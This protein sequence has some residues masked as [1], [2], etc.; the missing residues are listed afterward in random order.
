MAEYLAAL[1]LGGTS[2]CIETVD[3]GT[4]STMNV[5]SFPNRYLV[6]MAA[7]TA[8]KRLFVTDGQNDVVLVLDGWS[9][10]L[11]ATIPLLGP[12]GCLL[13]PDEK[14]LFVVSGT[15]G[16][17]KAIVNAIDTSTYAIKSSAVLSLDEWAWHRVA[18]SPDGSRLAIASPSPAPTVDVLDAATLTVQ[19][20]IA[21]P[22]DTFP[23]HPMFA[24]NHRLLVWDTVQDRL[25]QVDV[26]SGSQLAGATIQ[27]TPDV[28][29]HNGQCTAYSR[30]A[31]RAC[32]VKTFAGPA[33]NWAL[34]SI[35][36]I[37]QTVDTYGGFTGEPI[38]L[39]LSPEE[40]TALVA[41]D[42]RYS[43]VPGPPTLT[44]LDIPAKL[45]LHDVFTF[46][47][48]NVFPAWL[49]VVPGLWSWKSKVATT[50]LITEIIA[51]VIG[52]QGGVVIPP[53]R[54][55]TPWPP[56]GG[57][58]RE[59]APGT[60]DVLLGLALHELAG[61]AT[62]SPERSAI[63]SAALALAADGLARIGGTPG[64]T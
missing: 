29:I 51:G 35:D 11:I 53:G 12:T 37:A 61:L 40:R 48:P 8:L 2:P 18:L 14:T 34:A 16:F 50:A 17:S 45:I 46:A 20:E 42:H 39:C 56:W 36:P 22:A 33:I 1:M 43:A 21:F 23:Q 31:A 5:F 4:L 44:V 55:P 26:P 24:T 38:P 10:T 25:Y 60:R 30:L 7:T 19:H 3:L 57:R 52:D 47:T 64:S 32:V 62:A 6:A 54:P 15:A 63:Q 41:V 13:S 27:L 59:L 28:S 49:A 9:G 58:W